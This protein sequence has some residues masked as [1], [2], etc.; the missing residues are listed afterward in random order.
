[1]SK[2]P[3]LKGKGKRK[4]VTYGHTILTKIEVAKYTTAVVDSAS[5]L[6]YGTKDALLQDLM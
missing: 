3:T 5:L 4:R 1:M 2:D 6:L